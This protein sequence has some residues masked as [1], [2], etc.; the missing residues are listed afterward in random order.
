MVG[1]E[2]NTESTQTTN[3]KI[4][5]Q[6]I[7]ISLPDKLVLLEIIEDNSVRL[8]K[9]F[10]EFIQTIP[11]IPDLRALSSGY[12]YKEKILR[13]NLNWN[14]IKIDKNTLAIIIYLQNWANWKKPIEEKNECA[15]TFLLNPRPSFYLVKNLPYKFML[16][17]IPIVDNKKTDEGRLVKNLEIVSIDKEDYL[18]IKYGEINIKLPFKQAFC[19]TEKLQIGKKK[20]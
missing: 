3:N 18:H 7:D 19:Y 17:E 13:L 6:D 11:R 12:L 1:E 15:S 8:S 16:R 4:T 14:E 9:K 2:I 5:K 10:F 20:N